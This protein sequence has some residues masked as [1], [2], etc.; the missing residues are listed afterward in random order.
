MTIFLDYLLYSKYKLSRIF[1]CVVTITS[2]K[3]DTSIY[4]FCA[5]F[6]TL[7]CAWSR[8]KL[9]RRKGAIPCFWVFMAMSLPQPSPNFASS[10]SQLSW[11]EHSHCSCGRVYCLCWGP[12]R[13]HVPGCNASA[14]AQWKGD[15]AT[16]TQIS[17]TLSKN[18]P[19]LLKVIL[20][21]SPEIKNWLTNN[22]YH[23]PL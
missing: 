12:M 20:V 22:V 23:F 6:Q 2:F 11:R 4:P 15:R 3:K 10:A 5:G 8:Q 16:R 18:T 7:M 14:Q 21:I 1:V 9:S 13:C 19:S 17:E